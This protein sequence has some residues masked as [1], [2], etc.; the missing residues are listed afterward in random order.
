[1]TT[2]ADI[3]KLLERKE[4]KL[5]AVVAIENAITELNK[6]LVKRIEEQRAAV[7]MLVAEGFTCT[8]LKQIGIV[9]RRRPTNHT[10]AS[11]KPRANS[12][13]RA[14]EAPYHENI[15]NPPSKV[16]G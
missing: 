10:P 6:Q 14:I 8:E 2:P 11:K 16:P 5:T 15:V 9:R 1:M 7:D 3:K 4:A 13:L 12:P